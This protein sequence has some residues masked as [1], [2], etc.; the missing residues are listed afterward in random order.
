MTKACFENLP[1]PAC[2]RGAGGEGSW[3]IER[4]YSPHPNPLPKGEGTICLVSILV[5]TF[6]L[7]SSSSAADLTVK[8]LNAQAVKS[9][10]AVRRWDADG[11][12]RRQPD[13][14]AKIDRPALDAAAQDLGEGRWE[15]KN[16]EAGKYDLVI[17]A[18]DR[19][20]IEGFSYPPVREFDPLISADAKVD[21]E[22]QKTIFEMVEK[23]RHYEN[24]VEPLYLAGHEKAIRV[25]V[26]LVRDKP[27]SYESQSPGA[28]TI[29]HEIWQFTWRYGGWAKEKRT[30]VLDRLLLHRDELHKWTWLWTPQL[31]GIEV[32]AEPKSLEFKLPDLV[33]KQLKGLY[34]H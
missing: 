25:L 32:G 3:N 33:K 8:L 2:G 14:K 7:F 21:A 30:K 28:A 12:H 4:T 6:L 17:L 5:L 1:S 13:A 34:P 20:R 29:R 11:N 10:G 23:S 15:F 9:V 27:T 31:G 24:R 26:M 18:E 19:L 16:L 22:T